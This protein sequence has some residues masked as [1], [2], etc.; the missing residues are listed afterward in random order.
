MPNVA[1]AQDATVIK[2]QGAWGS[3]IFK[4]F[5]LDYVKRVKQMSGGSLRIDYL[6][7]DAV[8][9]TAKTLPFVHPIGEKYD[10]SRTTVHHYPNPNGG[11]ADWV[12]RFLSER[13]KSHIMDL[14]GAMTEAIC[15]DFRYQARDD[16]GVQTPM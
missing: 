16:P 7:V 13:G 12:R 14:L 15:Q 9:K 4:E 5:S 1:G 10:L 11:I 8:V 2:M 6:D 3:G